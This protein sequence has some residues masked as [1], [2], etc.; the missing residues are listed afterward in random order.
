MK[1]FPSPAF[2]LSLIRYEDA[3]EPIPKEWNLVL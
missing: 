2:A 3:P 1:D